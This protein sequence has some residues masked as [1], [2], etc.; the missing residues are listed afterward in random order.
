MFSIKVCSDK[1]ELYI[2]IYIV[3]T[4]FNLN[5][6]DIQSNCNIVKPFWNT[7]LLQNKTQKKK[8]TKFK[9][10]SKLTL[11]CGVVVTHPTSCFGGTGFK[12]MLRHRLY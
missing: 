3:L 6:T 4:A 8:Y 12:T 10:A 5:K 2:R 1:V 7:R 9:V 11:R